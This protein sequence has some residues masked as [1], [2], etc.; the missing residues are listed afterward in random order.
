MFK[1]ALFHFTLNKF[2]SLISLQESCVCYFGVKFFYK[3]SR[4]VLNFSCF[5]VVRVSD[6]LKPNLK[7]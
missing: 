1:R 4:H 3:F 6:I 2:F 5:F 7:V